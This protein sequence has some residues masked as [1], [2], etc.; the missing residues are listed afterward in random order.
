[1]LVQADEFT[2]GSGDGS[3]Q[4]DCRVQKDGIDHVSAG[5][6]AVPSWIGYWDS[7]LTNIPGYDRPPRRLV[8]YGV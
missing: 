3:G 5:L 6:C 2:V 8:G 7:D 4:K 1:V